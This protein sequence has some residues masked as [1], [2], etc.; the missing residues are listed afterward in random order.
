MGLPATG[1][2]VNCRIY[3]LSNAY[4]YIAGP[5][6]S[7]DQLQTHCDHAREFSTLCN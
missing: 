1:D 6:A 7:L 4:K 5:E 2:T 3:H